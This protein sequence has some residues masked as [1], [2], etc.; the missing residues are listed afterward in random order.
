MNTPPPDDF[1]RLIDA[2]LNDVIGPEDL[3]RLETGI[4]SSPETA[5]RF[6]RAARMDARLHRHFHRRQAAADLAARTGP[7]PK[8]VRLRPSWLRRAHEHAWG[9][10]A[11][12][13][14]HVALL[15]FLIRWVFIPSPA[16]RDE[17]VE[18]ALGTPP[19][20]TPLDRRPTLAEDT[21]GVG[22][23]VPAP[24]AISPVPAEVELPAWAD[25]NVAF[26]PL[27]PGTAAAVDP[28]RLASPLAAGR[29]GRERARRLALYGGA[30]SAAAEAAVSNAVDWLAARQD[31]GGRWHEAGSDPDALTGLVLLSLMGHGQT[32]VHGMHRDTVRAA[33]RH[34]AAEPAPPSVPP[35]TAAL[36]LCALADSVALTRLPVLHHALGTATAAVLDA[37]RPDG[38]WGNTGEGLDPLATAW[39]VEALRVA[40]GSGMTD[41]RIAA[42][43][44]RAADAIDRTANPT[45]GQL[46]YPSPA[47]HMSG[48]PADTA[49][50]V[51]ALQLSGATD[52]TRVQ[53]GLRA[54]D[55]MPA[56][57]PSASAPPA[58][59]EAVYLATRVRFNEGGGGWMKWMSALGPSL[60]RAAQQDG[61]GTVF[62]DRGADAHPIR[63]TALAVL[64]LETAYRYP[65]AAQWDLALDDFPGDPLRVALHRTLRAAL[66]L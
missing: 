59:F 23:R 7:L 1:D 53:R 38:G 35:R 24:P 17:G 49:A 52:R 32:P 30:W 56:A 6:A 11:A 43:I 31:A 25:L 28:A 10:V 61:K 39:S 21:S 58:D 66:A 15:V 4:R 19:D 34:L 47:Q 46:Y 51:L 62:S 9:P 48:L 65:P 20:R 42:A 33:L 57:W 22:P 55:A 40:A 64:V 5:L 12:V 63:A 13:A 36:R 50:A 44:A 18:I 14:L 3:A 60:L 29:F 2:Y 27:D 26:L 54:L 37:A 45:S 16:P 41:P 8:V